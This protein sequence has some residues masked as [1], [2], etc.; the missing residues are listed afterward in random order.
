MGRH[1]K[2]ITMSV[3]VRFRV[4]PSLRKEYLQHCKKNKINPSQKL[5]EFIINEIK[6]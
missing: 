6:K 1:K 4:E 2:E 3:Y 5:R